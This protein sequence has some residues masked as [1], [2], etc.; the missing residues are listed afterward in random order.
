MVGHGWIW[1]DI[2]RVIIRYDLILCHCHLK[3]SWRDGRLWTYHIAIWNRP[4]FISLVCEASA[5]CTAKRIPDVVAGLTTLHRGPCPRGDAP[6]RRSAPTKELLLGRPCDTE[7]WCPTK[8]V[9]N[10]FSIFLEIIYIYYIY[11]WVKGTNQLWSDFCS[12]FQIQIGPCA[13]IV[14]NSNDRSYLL[15]LGQ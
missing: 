6:D 4:A 9:I 2:I 12:R 1:L 3:S 7:K 15:Q 14:E 8:L 11:I 10:Y 5:V 13:V